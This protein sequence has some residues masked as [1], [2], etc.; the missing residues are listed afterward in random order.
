MMFSPP[1]L[2]YISGS[3]VHVTACSD[4]N[5]SYQLGVNELFMAI[6]RFEFT[7]ELCLISTLA[8][9]D[10][11]GMSWQH[12]YPRYCDFTFEQGRKKRHDIC[13]YLCQC[14]QPAEQ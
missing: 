7:A 6:K 13:L 4:V 3:S 5:F 10:F 11:T 9:D 12:S 14:L 2:S 8:L 1:I